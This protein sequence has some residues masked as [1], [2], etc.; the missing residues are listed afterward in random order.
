MTQE[1]PQVTEGTLTPRSDTNGKQ[2]LSTDASTEQSSSKIAQDLAIMSATD[3]ASAPDSSAADGA[4]LNADTHTYQPEQE[5]PQV[6]L[7]LPIPPEDLD[8]D[9]EVIIASKEKWDLEIKY[10]GL[11]V[12]RA[13]KLSLGLIAL[14]LIFILIVVAVFRNL[15]SPIFGNSASLQ[16]LI[17]WVPLVAIFGIYFYFTQAKIHQAKVTLVGAE[18][19]LA[20]KLTS[21]SKG[22]LSYYRGKLAKLTSIT[23]KI[24]FFDEERFAKAESLRTKAINALDTVA[25]NITM[26]GLSD[27]ETYLTTLEEIV[28]REERELKEQRAWQ[29]LAIAIMC[30][31]IGLLVLC[32]ILLKDQLIP[33]LN[34]PLAVIVWGAAGSLAAILYRFYTEQGRIRFSS[35]FRWLI[36]RPIIGIIMGAVVYLALVSGLILLGATPNTSS[37]P[38]GALPNSRFEVYSVI[39]FLAGFSDKF[40]LGVI[41]LLVARTVRTEEVNQNVVITEKQRVPEANNPENTGKDK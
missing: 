2:T 17:L 36:A 16:I 21:T 22:R 20:R 18:E 11:L 12:S 40:Y 27:V 31:Y 5:R 8:F 28:N 29:L 6:F 37:S 9:E 19:E 25:T 23:V 32:V 41:D 35:E 30:L 13:A 39:A 33:I 34:V 10:Q 38:E 4:K 24:F 15:F 3:R 14:I 26:A 1:E 7:P